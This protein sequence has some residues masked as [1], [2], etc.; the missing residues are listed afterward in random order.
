M[1]LIMQGEAPLV[2]DN[3]VTM[4]V[5]LVSQTS[6]ATPLHMASRVRVADFDGAI[7]VKLSVCNH[8]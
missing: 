8:F 1:D 2:A 7:C 5:E 3:G 4:T 6:G